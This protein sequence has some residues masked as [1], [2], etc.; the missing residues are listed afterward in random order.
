M[1]SL[2]TQE[3]LVKRRIIE[4]GNCSICQQVPE[5]VVHGRWE[6]GAAQDIWVGCP[7]RIQKCANGQ[8][9]ILQLFIAMLKKL[10][11]EEFELF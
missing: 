3:N 6:C 2:P 10:S 5:L 1:E 7:A 11:T 4:D 9:D 8:D